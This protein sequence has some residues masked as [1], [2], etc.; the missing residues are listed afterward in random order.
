MSTRKP[1]S[2]QQQQQPASVDPAAAEDADETESID[3]IE[4]NYAGEY[5][6]ETLNM[7][8]SYPRPRILEEESSLDPEQ[9]LEEYLNFGFQLPPKVVGTGQW[10]VGRASLTS[11]WSHL[12]SLLWPHL[13]SH[14]WSPLWSPLWSHLWSHLPFLGVQLIGTL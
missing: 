8:R 10:G 5:S 11:L 6:E 3:S 14:L 9:D 4:L 7:L 13:W 2:Q 1:Q 12:W